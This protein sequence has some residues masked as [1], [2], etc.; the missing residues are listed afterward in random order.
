VLA[1]WGAH[2]RLTPVR[3]AERLL[4][5]VPGARLE[6]LERAGHCAQLEEPAHVARLLVE[7][8]RRVLDVAKEGAC[9]RS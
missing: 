8:E 4:A 5:A 6:R 1:I 7:F 9:A 2:D 3:G